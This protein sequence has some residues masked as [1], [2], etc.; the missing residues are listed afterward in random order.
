MSIEVSIREGESQDSLLRR[1]QRMVQMTGVLRDAKAHRF[2]SEFDLTIVTTQLS[3]K[4]GVQKNGCTIFL[5]T[6]ATRGLSS[7]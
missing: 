3:W 4:G 6:L 2:A 7:Y 1:F 5:N